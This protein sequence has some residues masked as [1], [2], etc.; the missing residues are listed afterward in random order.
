M[1][2]KFGSGLDIHSS[3]IES[4]SEGPSQ[5]VIAEMETNLY[6][7]RVQDHVVNTAGMFLVVSD[8]QVVLVVAP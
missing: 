1:T 6:P 8:I 2:K 4:A 7:Q 5:V 3:M